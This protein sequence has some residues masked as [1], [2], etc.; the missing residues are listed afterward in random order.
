MFSD[1]KGLAVSIHSLTQRE[2]LEDDFFILDGSVSIHSLTQRETFDDYIIAQRGVF[3]STPSRRGRHGGYI[4]IPK[5]PRFNPL[6]HAEGDSDLTCSARPLTCF[7]PLPHAE[8]DKI[9]K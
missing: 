5:H 3:Q 2:T 7:N 6:P 4:P 1:G 8:G 9:A